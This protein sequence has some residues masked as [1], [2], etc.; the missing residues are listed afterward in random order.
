MT[1]AYPERRKMS[2]S[3]AAKLLGK[4][5]R[6]IRKAVA[7]PREQFL[8]RSNER[9]TKALELKNSGLKYREIGEIMGCT[10]RAAQGLVHRAR[11]KKLENP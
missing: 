7:E 4:S 8:A 11:Q 6:Y 1:A 10:E 2:A 5:E 9:I 3:E